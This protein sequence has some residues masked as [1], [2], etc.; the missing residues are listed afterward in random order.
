MLWNGPYMIF[1]FT[2]YFG[3]EMSRLWY[4]KKGRK[5]QPINHKY[6]LVIFSEVFSF[7]LFLAFLWWCDAQ[8]KLQFLE[9]LN[10]EF[11]YRMLNLRLFLVTFC[12]CCQTKLD[13]RIQL[14][15]YSWSF[16]IIWLALHMVKSVLG[17]VKHVSFCY[18]RAFQ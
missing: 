12:I 17:F 11:V 1:T 16:L 7:L 14:T 9:I 2:F 5:H 4:G 3:K 15:A 6:T 13:Y 8:S 18:L 10:L